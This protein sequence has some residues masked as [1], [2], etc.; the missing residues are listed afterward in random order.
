LSTLRRNREVDML[1]CSFLE[2][3]YSR[4]RDWYS[5]F[6]KFRLWYRGDDTEGSDGIQP[7]S[8]DV[9]YEQDKSL[10]DIESEW[11]SM[12]EQNREHSDTDCEV[13]DKKYAVTPTTNA[14]KS[15]GGED[16]Q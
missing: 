7:S 13:Q 8:D 6:D 4:R 10:K 11:S 3:T 16:V 12:E 5:K 14:A 9:Q 1:T 2:T 15:R